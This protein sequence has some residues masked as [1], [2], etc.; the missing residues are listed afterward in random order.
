MVNLRLE[1]TQNVSLRDLE[2]FYR[3]EKQSKIK[4]RALIII[5]SLEGKTTREAGMSAR[6]SHISASKWIKRFNKEGFDGLRDKPKTGRPSKA[7]HGSFDSIKDDLD[8]SPEEFGYN[9]QCWSTK[10][11]KKHIKEHYKTEYTDR[12]IIRILHKSGYSRIKPRPE[13]YRKSPAKKQGFKEDFKKR[14]YWIKT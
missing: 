10:L 6:M 2:N 5:S 11:L 9:Q 12:H 13:D 7:A 1:I 4:E 8:K 14:A 3:K